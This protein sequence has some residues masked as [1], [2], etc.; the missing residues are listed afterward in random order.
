MFQNMALRDHIY[1]TRT[2]KMKLPHGLQDDL[3]HVLADEKIM[4]KKYSLYFGMI[5]YSKNIHYSK[6][7]NWQ[8]RS[9]WPCSWNG[10]TTVHCRST[11]IQVALLHMVLQY[12]KAELDD[13]IN[14]WNSVVDQLVWTL[15]FV[16]GN[17]WASVGRARK[18]SC[19]KMCFLIPVQNLYMGIQFDK[20]EI[21]E[22]T[23]LALNTV[24]IH[25][26]HLLIMMNLSSN[27]A[28]YKN[29][30][31]SEALFIKEHKPSLNEQ[32]QSTQLSL[33]N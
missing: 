28:N 14:G 32:G 2:S 16:H 23:Q 17:S 1:A 30:K 18:L 10:K 29:I 24:K 13:N 21:Y 9:G 4:H 12:D 19:F 27:Y 11:S 20:K 5:I 15:V 3:F 22:K 26:I 7:T 31:I 6:Y 8:N 33:F 25:D